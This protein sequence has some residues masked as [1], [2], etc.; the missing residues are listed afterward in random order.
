MLK[1]PGQLEDSDSL[2]SDYDS[3]EQDK[4]DSPLPVSRQSKSC[5]N[6]ALKHKQTLKSGFT[7]VNQLFSKMDESRLN[8]KNKQLLHKERI[9]KLKSKKNE[10][11]VT[12]DEQRD[13]IIENLFQ[14][15]DPYIFH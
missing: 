10:H 3:E 5:M 6:S 4:A 15:R 8:K 9:L 7:Y 2:R 11:Q 14:M 1:I 13:K 12:V